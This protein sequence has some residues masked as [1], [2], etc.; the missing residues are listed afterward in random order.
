MIVVLTSLSAAALV[1]FFRV[2]GRNEQF[3]AGL[4]L[5]VAI[6]SL[7]CALPMHVPGMWD[8]VPG[9]LMA[10]GALLLCSGLGKKTKPL[11]TWLLSPLALIFGG[12]VTIVGFTLA[13]LC[14]AW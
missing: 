2:S 14:V 12:F 8:L 4:F 5:A 6:V 3:K 7:T 13:Q 1:C 10:L 9:P 11:E